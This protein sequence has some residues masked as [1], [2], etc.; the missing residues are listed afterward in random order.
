MIREVAV[1]GVGLIGGSFA[2]ALRKAG[3]SGTITGVSSE[4]TLARAAALGIVD[5]SATLENAA[6]SADLIYLAQPIGGILELLPRLAE[7]S[8]RGALITDAGST[9]RV[10]LE[11]A[12]RFFAPARFIGGHP[13]A[14]KE[15]RGV[16]NAD[17][18]LFR[19]RPYILTPGETSDLDGP[20]AREFASWLYRI[21]ARVLVMSASEHDH[22]VG[23]VSHLPQLAATALAACIGFEFPAQTPPSGPALLDSTRLA[24]SSFDIWADILKTNGNT[25]TFALDKYIDQLRLVRQM[26]GSDELAKVFQNGGAFARRLRAGES[27]EHSL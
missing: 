8:A 10:I 24:L 7:V 13:L 6:R 22:V 5:R 11:T 19:G 15:S 16:E 20:A 1:V 25:I 12:S 18:D 3:F 9:K 27:E 2:L 23:F 17:P 14:G 26:I 21:G 4:T